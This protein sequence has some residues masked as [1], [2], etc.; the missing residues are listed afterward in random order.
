MRTLTSVLGNSQRLDGGAMFGN[1]PRSLWQT[2]IPSD[3]GNRIPVA[4]R[5]L[6]VRDGGR[7]LLFE[8]GSGA[9]LP[10]AQR[11]RHGVVEPHHVL[12]ASL[13]AVGIALARVTRD[14]RGRFHTVEEQ[15][16]LRDLAA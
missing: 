3:D 11:E 10:P 7:T 16:E 13:A 5:C 4:C 8:A 2:W 9:F 12:L 14:A 6:V 1:A 15:P